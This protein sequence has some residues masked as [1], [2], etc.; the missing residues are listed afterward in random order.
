MSEPSL[1][2]SGMP[3][4]F[5]DLHGGDNGTPHSRDA[6][7]L[8]ARIPV[9]LTLE[10]GSVT[11]MLSELLELGPGSVLELDRSAGTPLPIKLNGTEVGT[12]ETVVSGDSYGLRIVSLQDLSDLAP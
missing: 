11:L 12:G 6:L 10:V 3:D 5:D 7:R 9:K 2:Q 8:L 4:A 1:S